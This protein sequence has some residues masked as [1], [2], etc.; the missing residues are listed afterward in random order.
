M[1]SACSS[2]FDEVE[3]DRCPRSNDHSTTRSADEAIHEYFTAPTTIPLP[4][5]ASSVAGGTS[6]VAGSGAQYQTTQRGNRSVLSGSV[7]VDVRS[8]GTTGNCQH[9]WAQTSSSQRNLL[10]G[11]SASFALD[12]VES[13]R[14]AFLMN[15][16]AATG[17]LS[18]GF[19][20]PLAARVAK[21]S[22]TSKGPQALFESQTDELGTCKDHHTTSP[23]RQQ[24]QQ[25]Q[26]DH[27]EI[28]DGT[29]GSLGGFLMQRGISIAVS[30]DCEDGVSSPKSLMRAAAANRHH[31]HYQPHHHQHQQ[32][33]H[34]MQHHHYQHPLY[35]RSPSLPSSSGAMQ[36]QQQPSNVVQLLMDQS[37]WSLRSEAIG[38]AGAHTDS[39]V[40][41]MI[42]GETVGNAGC[43][44]GND[45]HHF[46][47]PTF[48]R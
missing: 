32:L 10:V 21:A 16:S 26:R 1:G 11:S 28:D 43:K 4:R 33:P 7:L 46:G 39:S 24:Q 9:D 25:Q 22:A 5:G 14:S 3:A 27:D 17:I 41:S 15:S 47:L 35:V 45:E 37:Q 18:L 44:L 34:H 20:P 38:I 42:C 40:W 13:S 8:L 31:H 36:Q 12:E 2:H 29:E 19:D 23:S 6:A 48:Q 30:V